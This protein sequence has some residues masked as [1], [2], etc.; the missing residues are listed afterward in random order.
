MKP[1]N[2]FFSVSSISK[3]DLFAIFTEK[4]FVKKATKW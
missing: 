3:I 1:Q 2:M 4:K